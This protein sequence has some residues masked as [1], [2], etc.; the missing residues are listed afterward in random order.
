MLIE[1][2][3]CDNRWDYGGDKP[4]GAET[5]CPECTYKTAIEP[6]DP[7]AVFDERAPLLSTE[8]LTGLL[9][10]D[11]VDDRI[12]EEVRAI[13]VYGSFVNPDARIDYDDA[14]ERDA[15]PSDLSDLD[16]WIE[17]THDRTVATRYRARQHGIICRLIAQDELSY[18]GG[19]DLAEAPID[20]AGDA[21]DGAVATIEAA[22][23]VV[24]ALAERDRETLGFRAL[25]LALG[26]KEAFD[27]E[28]GDDP[29]LTVW[30]RDSDD[31]D[32]DL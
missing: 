3:N 31:D 10:K 12:R 19:Q 4:V 5:N 21:P 26:D 9:L 29:F 27:N 16:V 17:W 24:F 28:V 1:C 11:V 22:E 2:H 7:A 18:P 8:D 6:V 25:E 32:A 15:H 23:R 30:E 14:L 20:I 13:H